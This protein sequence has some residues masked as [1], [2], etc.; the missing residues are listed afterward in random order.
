[1]SVLTVENVKKSFG[2]LEVIKDISFSLNDGEV[3]AIIGPSG[4]GKST[5][6]RSINMLE[7]VDGGT[8]TI[9]D[10]VLVSGEV[11]VYAS[12]EMQRKIRLNTGLVFQNYNLFPHFSVLRNITEAPVRVLGMDKDEAEKIAR[13]LLKKMGLS[14]S[15]S[16][17]GELVTGQIPS[18][19][20][21]IPGGGQVLLY[22]GE[23]PEERTVT[24]PDFTGMTRQQASD[25]SGGL[26][27]LISGNPA[28]APAVT[29]AT[30][31]IPAGAQVKLGT[32]VTL[33][34]YD[35]AARD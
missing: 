3:L 21:S 12:K 18:A 14:A 4:S 20:Q 15:F 31:N 24:V 28:A 33:T 26:Y 7:T 1:M 6:L 32:T 16:G 25:A 13:E 19:G 5:L 34:F 27:L 11:P 10:D 30:Q 17:T 9:C 29:V 23:T 22:L 2:D 35:Q 8:I